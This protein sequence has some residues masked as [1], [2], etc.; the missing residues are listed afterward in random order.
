[1]NLLTSRFISRQ[2]LVVINT[3]VGA[4]GLIRS[5]IDRKKRMLTLEYDAS[6]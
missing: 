1:M 3:L 5:R 4:D 6:G 2:V